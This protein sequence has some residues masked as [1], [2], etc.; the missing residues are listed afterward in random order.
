MIIGQVLIFSGTSLQK[1][2]RIQNFE[3]IT[4]LWTAF[5]QNNETPLIFFQVVLFMYGEAA[6]QYGEAGDVSDEYGVD[7]VQ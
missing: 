3:L 7:C 5:V 6:D 4:F 2:G 1:Y